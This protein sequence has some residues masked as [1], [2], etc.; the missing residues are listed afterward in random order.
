MDG[1]GVHG[2][3]E[4][5]QELMKFVVE[6]TPEKTEGN[7]SAPIWQAALTFLGM[8]E[9]KRA[10]P[11]LVKVLKDKSA[12]IGAIVG[13]VRALERMDDDSVIPD[14]RE[15]LKRDDLPTE[16]TLQMSMGALKHIGPAT[17]EAKWQI[18]LAVAETLQKLG[19][20]QEEVSQIAEPHL[21][22]DRAHVRRYARKLLSM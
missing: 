4:G 17:E 12:G 2:V 22:D 14:L 10:I 6:R 8:T 16:R 7:K 13:A 5:I 21:D 9:D 20:P 3:E 15:L 18:D 11:E 1:S 19:A